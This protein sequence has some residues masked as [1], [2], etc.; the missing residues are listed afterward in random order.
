MN[1]QL[2]FVW[3]H[4]PETSNEIQHRAVVGHGVRDTKGRELGHVV[5]IHENTKHRKTPGFMPFAAK[6]YATRAGSFF[7]AGF[8][9]E[10]LFATLDEAKRAMEERVLGFR[11]K[12]AA[13]AAK[14]GGI[15]Q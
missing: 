15:Y 3:T 2:E 1:Q 11:K 14:T 4:G 6:A 8:P 5:Y 13:K 12:I 9:P 7:G 10:Y